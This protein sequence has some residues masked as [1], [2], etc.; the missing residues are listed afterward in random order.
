MR[1]HKLL[2]ILLVVM[3]WTAWAGLA[4]AESFIIF[5]IKANRSSDTEDVRIMSKMLENE[6]RALNNTK[7]LGTQGEKCGNIKCAKEIRKARGVDAVVVGEMSYF[8]GKRVLMLDVAW[9]DAV[10]SYDPSLMDIQEFKKLKSRL[11]KAIRNREDWESVRGVDTV[12]D[13]EKE[14][15]KQKVHGM[16]KFGFGMGMLAP[17]SNTFLGADYLMG[18]RGLFRYEITNIGIEGGAGFYYSSNLAYGLTMTEVPIELG[19]H[20]YFM[21]S[22]FS[23]FAGLMVGAHPIWV[24]HEEIDDEV[25][26]KYKDNTSYWM[27]TLAPYIGV[28]LLRTHTF[29]INFRAGYQYGFVEFDE[30]DMENEIAKDEINEGAHGFFFQVG[31]TFGGD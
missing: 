14:P 3:A 19:A 8:G 18:F 23:P 15:Y 6:L 26:D 4:L 30:I 20:Y 12:S 21:N 7:V 11:A 2:I 31:V 10:Y 1:Q 16:W 9:A 29:Q 25:P 17:M 28:E 22:D 27:F 5:P 24:N 13:E